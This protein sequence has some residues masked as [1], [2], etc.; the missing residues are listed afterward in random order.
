MLL[1][2][3]LNGATIFLSNMKSTVK[4]KYDCSCNVCPW[5]THIDE[6]QL[7]SPSHHYW[8]FAE[9]LSDK[10]IFVPPS[11]MVSFQMRKF[12]AHKYEPNTCW[13]LRHCKIPFCFSLKSFNDEFRQLGFNKHNCTWDCPNH[14]PKCCQLELY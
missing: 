13:S 8:S 6:P 3:I 11:K 2:V 10:E 9:H 5:C 14:P 1:K 12:Q 4:S 7:M